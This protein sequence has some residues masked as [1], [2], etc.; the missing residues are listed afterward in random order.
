[1]NGQLSSIDDVEDGDDVG[2]IQ[3]AGRARLGDEASQPVRIGDGSF[4]QDLQRDL[5]LQPRIPR[6]IHFAAAA[7]PERLEEFVGAER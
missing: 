5:A 6:A 4:V 3:R 7:L 2:M 1:M